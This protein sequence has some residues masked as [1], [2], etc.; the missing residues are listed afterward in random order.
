MPYLFHFKIL[1]RI[2]MKKFNFKLTFFIF[3]INS[4]LS[5]SLPSSF[6]DL[7]ENLSPA[8]VSIASTT[9]VK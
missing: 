4:N 1:W 8:V 6:A 5:F 7:V 9:I 2:L 3:L